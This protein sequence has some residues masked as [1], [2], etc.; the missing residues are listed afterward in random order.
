MIDTVAPVGTLTAVA[1][2]HVASP[3]LTGAVD[4][5]TATVRVTV[6]GTSYWAVN[7]G[8]GT[9]TLPAG[10]I[11]PGLALGG[12]AVTVRFADP[13]GNSSGVSGEV[14]I[15]EEEPSVIDG[16]TDGTDNTDG[17]GAP[18]TGLHFMGRAMPAWAVISMLL[19]MSA[20]IAGGILYAAVARSRRNGRND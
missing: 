18:N 15:V 5:P 14:E 9:W 12:H 20:V 1:P 6:D 13:T 7:N 4:D 17:A 8:D 3:A 11:T 2:G 16:G 10:T 19:G